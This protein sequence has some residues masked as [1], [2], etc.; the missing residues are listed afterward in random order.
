MTITPR[1]QATSAAQSEGPAPVSAPGA[2]DS[3]RAR[4]TI[5]AIV[6]MMLYQGFAVSILGTASP[7]IARDFHLGQSGIARALA[8]VS[9]SSLGSLA[10]SRAVDRVGRRRV[11]LWCIGA[12]PL[13]ELGAALSPSLAAFIVFQTIFYSFVGASAASSIVMLSE[14]LPIERRAAGQ[15]YGGLAMGLGGG[16]TVFLMP[17]LVQ[18]HHSW[19]WLLVLASAGIALVPLIRRAMPESRRWEHALSTGIT[20]VARFYD[21]FGPLYRR[22]AGI[23]LVCSLLSTIATTATQSWIYF[24]AVSVVK[25]AP[26]IASALVIVGG[27]VGLLG[28]PLGARACEHFGRVRTVVTAG[29]ISSVS[30]IWFYWGPPA[31]FGAPALWLGIAFA[32]S[33]SAGN[34]A[35]V[36]ANTAVT[37]LFPTA[38]RATMIGW[39]AIMGAIGSVAA[40]TTISLLAG[41][42]GGLSAVVGWLA[43]LGVPPALLFGLVIEETRGMSLEQSAREDAFVDTRL[44]S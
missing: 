43:M 26:S 30:W 28:F 3:T 24:H 9:L 34:A 4:A 18:N 40:Q 44:G 25:L 21:V 14:E 27:G 8:W 1:T 20:S 15:S 12:M 11:L 7:W 22:R 33:S 13:C 17:V 31:H 6:V 2:E 42:L 39:F 36:G 19:R 5:R 32:C 38:L 10:L 35:M 41:P 16:L 37:E 29:L 23:L